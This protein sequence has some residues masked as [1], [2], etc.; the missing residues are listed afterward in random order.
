MNNH[1]YHNKGTGG[2]VDRLAKAESAL[3]SG[4]AAPMRAL[5]VTFSDNWA[6]LESIEAIV[7]RVEDSLKTNTVGMNDW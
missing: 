1:Q 4:N 3:K 2:L 5:V 7:D 6:V